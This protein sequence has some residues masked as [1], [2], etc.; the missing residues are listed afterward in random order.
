MTITRRS[1]IAGSA[2]T[3]LLRPFGA[4]ATGL[5][6]DT[7]VAIIGAGAAGIAAARRIAAS[8]KRVLVLEATA[9]IGGRCA[10]D[11]STFEVPFDRGARW[12]YNSDGNPLI[13]PARSADI[14]LAPAP[15]GQRIRIER[16]NA[17]AGETEDF[18]ALVVRAN[19][20][21]MEAVRGRPDMPALEALPRDFLE[22]WGG[23]L[24]FF[25]GAF[26]TGCDLKD[27]S[28][29]DLLTLQPREPASFSRQ[30]LGTLIARLAENVPVALSTPVTR[31]AWSGR[32]A[33]VETEAGTLAARA[34]IVTASTGVLN[35]GKIKFSPDLPKRQLDAL[36]KLVLGSTDR[37]ALELPGN[38]LGLGRDDPY[39]EKSSDNR[40]AF[41]LANTGGSSLCQV[42]VAGSFGR[43]L[44]A[45]GEKAMTAFAL[46]WLRKLFGGD[47]ARAVRHTVTTRWND[48]PY[49]MG[50]MSAALPGGQPSRKILTEPLGPLFFAGD[51][52]HETLWGTAGGAWVSGER[53]ADAALRKLSGKI[54]GMAQ[55]TRPAKTSRQRHSV[56][57]GSTGGLA[58][59]KQRR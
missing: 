14:V 35:A 33:Q 5:P 59:P 18:L 40:T 30:G 34:V 36:S 53:A 23:T 13:A 16:R 26:A 28:A 11:T 39:I 22:E 45:Q 56:E 48:A 31:I 24:D 50:A 21:M 55:D 44:A 20:A 19:R 17:R 3:A 10:T 7:D 42:D 6:R 47:P 1:L 27:I 51:A 12:L 15:R 25:L 2:A 9:L 41:L 58:W 29:A 4:R 37:I 38:P 32:D 43:D 54:E 52:V 8:G 57:G 49:V 46:E